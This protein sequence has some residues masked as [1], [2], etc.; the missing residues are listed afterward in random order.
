MHFLFKLKL[1]ED[2]INQILFEKL[3]H[4]P[5][6][7]NSQAFKNRLTSPGTVLNNLIPSQIGNYSLIPVYVSRYWIP[8]C[9]KFTVKARI[10]GIFYALE[11][12]N[13]RKRSRSCSRKNHG[14]YCPEFTVDL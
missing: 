9:S 2:K 6:R 4:S 13:S 14:S 5:K 3:A 1:T 8:D 11:R 12:M 7:V 10:L